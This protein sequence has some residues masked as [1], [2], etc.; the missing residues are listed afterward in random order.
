MSNIRSQDIRALS[1]VEY[2]VLYLIAAGK[3]CASLAQIEQGVAGTK[4]GRRPVVAPL[5]FL[6]K[7][8]WIA[9]GADTEGRR[10]EDW[11]QITSSGS[12]RL[13]VEQAR[14]TREHPAGESDADQKPKGAGPKGKS[15]ANDSTG[16]KD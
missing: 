4:L 15:T 9:Y 13:V 6:Y 7:M 10:R 11:Y 14:R 3:P 2:T 1:D 5:E 16:A 8:G 12:N